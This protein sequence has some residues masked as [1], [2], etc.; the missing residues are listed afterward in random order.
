MF[1]IYN[2]NAPPPFSQFIQVAM[3][4]DV[5]SKIIISFFNFPFFKKKVAYTIYIM[6][7]GQLGIVEDKMPILF[8][9]LPGGVI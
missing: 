8:W 4:F 6:L 7:V 2:L 9:N 5:L 1:T 3:P